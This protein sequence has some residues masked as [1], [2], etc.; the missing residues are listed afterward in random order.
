MPLHFWVTRDKLVT[1][2]SD[3]R[4]SLRLQLDPW[5]DKLHAAISAPEALFVMLGC[6][7]ETFILAS[8]VS[9]PGLASSSRR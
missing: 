2:Q 9:R 3:M 1:Y 8:T 7:L 5:H 4:F 6:M